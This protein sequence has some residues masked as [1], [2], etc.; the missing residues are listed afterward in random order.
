MT[1]PL[2]NF[3]KALGRLRE[4][5]AAPESDLSRDAAIQRFEF[6]VELGWKSVKALARDLGLDCQSPKACLRLAFA[7]GWIDD[8]PRWI[9]LLEDRNRTS[10][11]YDEEFARHLFGRLPGYVPLLEALHH[12]LERADADG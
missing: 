9:A 1:A 6:S 12:N 8:E 7:Q 5:L 10:H 11:T 3:G 4:A 2:H